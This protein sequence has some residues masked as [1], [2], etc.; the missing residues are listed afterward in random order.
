MIQHGGHAETG[1]H[2]MR[3]RN[4]RRSGNCN[5]LAAA[6]RRGPAGGCFFD[7]K[8]EI[9]RQN[10]VYGKTIQRGK[11]MNNIVL[12]DGSCGSALWAMA[13]ARGI[14]KDPTWK[15]NVE[16]PELVLE[17]HRRYIAVGSDMIQT[18]TFAVNGPSVKRSSSYS[19]EKIIRSAAELAK[20]AAEGTGV[21]TYLSCGPL[22][23]LLEPYGDLEEDECRA[24]YDEITAAAAAGGVDAIM[25]ET[26]MD[27]EMMKIAAA[28]ALS[29]N[30][31]V[32]CSMTF[33]KKHRTMLGNKIEQIC[34]E[35][36][37]MGVEAVGMNCSKGPVEALEV[38]REFR[39][40][41]D[42][43][44]Y[45]KPNSGMGE[46]YSA[47]QFADE[48]APALDLVKYVGGCCGTDES[49]IAELRNRIDQ[50]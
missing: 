48:I 45:F 36:A 25:L 38:I 32:I 47:K 26:F 21:K 19:V 11:D 12:L 1:M 18:N 2:L 14:K 37:P 49:Y 35:L 39:E 4:K 50:R 10:E 43:P 40:F 42:L 6:D 41:T 17:L 23:Q 20:Q 31:P 28:S 15:Y 9:A 33:E 44:L 29:R 13:E 27:L 8:T 22:T 46:T 34:E 30:L 16:H 5:S 24:F 7:A 3:K